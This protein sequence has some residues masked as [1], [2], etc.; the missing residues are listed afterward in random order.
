[1]LLLH[2]LIIV[3]SIGI[4]KSKWNRGFVLGFLELNFRNVLGIR[5]LLLAL[6]LVFH[7]LLDS[8]MYVNRIGIIHSI[9]IIN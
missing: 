8:L 2:V 5:E 7:H 4:Y 6:E 3:S 1:M 9:T